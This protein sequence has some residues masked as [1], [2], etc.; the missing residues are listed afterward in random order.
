MPLSSDITAQL[1]SLPISEAVLA[2]AAFPLVFSPIVLEAHTKDCTYSEPDWL[3]AAR[4]N[5]E[6]TS[7]MKAHARALESYA[8][9][10]Q[11]KFVKLLDGGITDNFGTTALSVERARSV[12]SLRSRYLPP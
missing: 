10:E 12:S 11:V 6:A 7:A 5:P 4:Y 1:A 8:N 9:P 3:T 2:S